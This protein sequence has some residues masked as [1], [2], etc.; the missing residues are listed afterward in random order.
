MVPGEIEHDIET[1]Y[2]RDGIVL[3]GTTVDDIAKAA[4]GLKVD[5]SALFA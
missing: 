5:A 3:A 2:R 4:A 1:A